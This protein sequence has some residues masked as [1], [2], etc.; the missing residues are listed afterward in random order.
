MDFADYTDE[1]KKFEFGFIRVIR[2]I[3]GSIFLF[4][5]FVLGTGVGG[6]RSYD[7]GRFGRSACRGGDA[8]SYIA[9]GRDLSLRLSLVRRSVDEL[10]LDPRVRGQANAVLNSCQQE[11]DDLVGQMEKGALPSSRKV[12]GV[13][14]DLRAGR[15]ELYEIIGPQESEQL[16]EMLRSLRGEARSTLAHVRLML[17]EM[18]PPPVEMRK[19][20]G[21]ISAAEGKAES[22][23]HL[24]LSAEEYDAQRGKLDGILKSV[25]EQLDGVLTPGE[26]ERLGPRFTASFPAT[27]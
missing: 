23:P 1:E 5:E 15:S 18:I 14:G 13:P 2:E 22:F 12:L 3:R 17:Q 21:I 26:L 6:L 25:E 27:K 4:F 10:S 19:C 20:E 9:I 7:G 8:P 16:D 24:D 11:V